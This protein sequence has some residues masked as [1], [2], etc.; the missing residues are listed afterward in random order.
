MVYMIDTIIGLVVG[1][2]SLYFLRQQNQIFKAQ[3]EIF[4]SQ[5]GK[6]KQRMQ[7]Q[8]SIEARVKRHWPMIGMAILV[9][10]VWAGGWYGYYIIH[11]ENIL[12]FDSQRLPVVVGYGAGPD[13]CAAGVEGK[14]WLAYRAQYRLAI[15]CFIWDQTSDLFDAPNVQ[16]SSLY[17][18]ADKEIAMR[19]SY[20][21]AYLHF[22]SEH[23][24]HAM[25]IVVFLVPNEVSTSEFATLR[26]ARALGVHIPTYRR[27][28]W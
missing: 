5:A 1:I 15:G 18:I 9:S 17:D 4:A 3:N 12:D 22:L 14:T 20:S 2:A 16:I 26:Q 11:R 25:E 6:G 27:F 8:P 7:A 13:G 19:I 10:L 23:R 28:T 24:A 21:G